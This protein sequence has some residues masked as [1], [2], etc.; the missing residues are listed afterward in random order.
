MCCES[1]LLWHA[2]ILPCPALPCPALELRGEVPC[3]HATHKPPEDVTDNEGSDPA[4][5]LSERSQAADPKA[6][7][8]RWG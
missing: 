5:G 3:E 6:F 8:H 2:R 7:E 4:V 1:I